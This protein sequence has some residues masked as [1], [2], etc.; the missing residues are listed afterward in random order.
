L[1][2]AKTFKSLGTLA[3]HR[4]TVHA[5]AFPHLPRERG[6]SDCQDYSTVGTA[7]ETSVIEIVEEDENSTEEEE[8][9]QRNS[10][11]MGKEAMRWMVSAGKDRRLALWQLKDFS[12]R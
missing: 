11:G 3:Y 7:E 9:G 5:I 4:Q 6:S 12:Q 10:R 8:D 2:S 1:Y